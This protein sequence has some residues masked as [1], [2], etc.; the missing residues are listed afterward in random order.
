MA[1]KKE[2]AKTAAEAAVAAHY[3]QLLGGCE[4]RNSTC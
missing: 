3:A 1:A 4:A 2:K